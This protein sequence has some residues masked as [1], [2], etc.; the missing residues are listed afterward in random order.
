MRRTNPIL[1]TT[2]FGLALAAS[3][4]AA[5]TLRLGHDQPKAHGYQQVGVYLDEKLKE[6]TNGEWGVAIFPSAQL[7]NEMAMLDSVMSGNLDMSVAASANASTFIPELGL[8]S[9]SYIFADADH[10]RRVLKDPEF[11]ALVDEVVASHDLGLKRLCTFTAG[12]RNVYNNDHPV[13][14]LDDLKGMKMRVMASPVE[15]QVWNQLGTLPVSIPF[16]DVY[17]GMQTGLV[18]AAENAAAVYGS[19]KHYEVAPYYSLTGHQWLVAFLF[20]NE[21][22]FANLPDNVKQTIEENCEGL[23]DHVVDYVIESDAQFLKDLQEEYDVQVNEVDTAPFVEALSE[24]QDA[25]AKQ[26]GAEGLLERVR[27]LQ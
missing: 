8:F 17:T 6:A 26:L 3:P 21:E 7:G 10:F 15:S 9:V 23:T 5:E 12:V 14:S 20:T 18:Q 11:N 4:A 22:E 27:A 25:V 2:L 19:N 24:T 13:A 16:G 1:L